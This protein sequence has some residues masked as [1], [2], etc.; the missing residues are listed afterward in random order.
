MPAAQPIQ[1]GIPLDMPDRAACPT[2]IR[3]YLPRSAEIRSALNWKDLRSRASH[4]R[5]LVMAFAH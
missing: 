4:D 2:V 5:N 3:P 1:G